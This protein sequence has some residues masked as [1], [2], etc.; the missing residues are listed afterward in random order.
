MIQEV[1]H[2]TK[3]KRSIGIELY[4]LTSV[5]QIFACNSNEF[6]YLIKIVVIN[7]DEGTVSIVLIPLQNIY[8][9]I[10]KF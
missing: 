4:V 3:E 7:Y 6:D 5:P 2:K 10:H 8:N 9:Y 1:I